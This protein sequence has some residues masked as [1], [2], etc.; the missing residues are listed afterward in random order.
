M[1]EE[2]PIYQVKC[3]DSECAED[4]LYCW[5][6][7]DGPGEWAVQFHCPICDK[8]WSYEEIDVQ[9]LKREAECQK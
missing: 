1:S 7:H 3:P 5:L 8:K 4:E 2:S 6:R 9:Q